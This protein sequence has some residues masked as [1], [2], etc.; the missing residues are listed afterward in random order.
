MKK[1][2][3]TILFFAILLFSRMAVGQ[4][5][6]KSVDIDEQLIVAAQAGDTATAQQ[7]LDKGANIN[8]NDGI[9]TALL[10]ATV[11]HKTE[12]VKLLLEK[13]AHTEDRY[14]DETALQRAAD[15][16]NIE[17]MKLLLDHGANAEATYKYLGYTAM[18]KAAMDGK[19]DMVE[20]L[21]AKG[22]KIEAMDQNGYTALHSAAA[23]GH[24]DVV[25]LLLQKG[26]KIEARVGGPAH[27][28][29]KQDA[30]QNPL[31]TMNR[32]DTALILA[33]IQGRTEVVKLL[34]YWGAKVLARD[35]NGKNAIDL[36]LEGKNDDVTKML[37]HARALVSP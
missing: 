37:W 13:G 22:V 5:V 11:L 20:L 3:V 24:A 4:A 15:D 10:W 9:G 25:K 27:K 29:S 34:L 8:A 7:L 28:G 23:G 19:I 26:A 17:V 36:A 14:L 2:P 21:L 12:M 18:T 35:K 32:G 6:G 33:V 30:S 1:V 31:E 16:G